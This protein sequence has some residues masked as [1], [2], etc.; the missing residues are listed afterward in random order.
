MLGV[1]L[2]VG[3]ALLVSMGAAVYGFAKRTGRSQTLSRLGFNLTERMVANKRDTKRWALICLTFAVCIIGAE[4]SVTYV[5]IIGDARARDAFARELPCIRGEK[6]RCN[7]KLNQQVAEAEQHTRQ[8]AFVFACLLIGLPTVGGIKSYLGYRDGQN[9]INR[10]E[11]QKA[12][13]AELQAVR[14]DPKRQRASRSMTDL[15]HAFG[16]LETSKT[17][18]AN[19]IELQNLEM[20]NAN[21]KLEALKTDFN[22]FWTN[23][24][25]RLQRLHDSAV[26]AQQDFEAYLDAMLEGRKRIPGMSRGTLWHRFVGWLTGIAPTPR[27]RLNGQGGKA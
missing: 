22:L 21:T 17:R 14:D 27:T 5:G 3:V 23:E 11:R 15:H 26:A 13:A 16:H 10:A 1:M 18:S 25:V 19:L 20:Q 6:V 8:I 4:S 7:P 2:P 24:E 9:E 12:I